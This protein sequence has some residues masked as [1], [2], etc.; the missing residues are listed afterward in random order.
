MDL[1]L[2]FAAKHHQG[3]ER[4]APNAHEFLRVNDLRHVSLCMRQI[5]RA[6]PTDGKRQCP[7]ATKAGGYLAPV[8]WTAPA[9]GGWI[10]V[11]FRRRLE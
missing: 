6:I 8:V 5:I 4:G 1:I 2:T 10:I 3:Q 11:F 7:T 9:R